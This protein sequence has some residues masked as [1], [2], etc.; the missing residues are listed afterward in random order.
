LTADDD[1]DDDD[2]DRIL[3]DFSGHE[4]VSKSSSDKLLALYAPGRPNDT[5]YTVYRSHN[6]TLPRK[7]GSTTQC[8]FI[9]RM[10]FKDSY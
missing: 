3:D 10:L 1:N 8:D 6:L 5:K 7:S 9:T 4:S 2:E